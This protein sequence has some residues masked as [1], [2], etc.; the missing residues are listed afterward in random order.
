MIP[1]HFCFKGTGAWV[2]RLMV[3]LFVL[4]QK[5]FVRVKANRARISIV[6]TTTTKL[7]HFARYCY[8]ILTLKPV[9]DLK[10]TEV[11]FTSPTFALAVS[12]FLP[13]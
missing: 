1:F 2:L 10:R 7:V 4:S 8:I 3:A 11:T 6:T 13:Y 9:W 5:M 12:S